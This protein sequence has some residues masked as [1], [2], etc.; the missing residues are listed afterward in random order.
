VDPAVDPQGAFEKAR[1]IRCLSTG[2]RTA[3][4]RKGQA[5]TSRRTGQPHGGGDRRRAVHEEERCQGHL[6]ASRQYVSIESPLGTS[7]RDGKLSDLIE[8]ANGHEPEDDLLTRDLKDTIR[9]TLM[10]LS[11][12]E[13]GDQVPLRAGGVKPMSLK[14]WARCSGDQGA[15]PPDRE[16]GDQGL[17][18]PLRSHKWKISSKADS[19]RFKKQKTRRRAVF[20]FC[21]QRGVSRFFARF[22]RHRR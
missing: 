21:R 19:D 3:A 16:K 15:D 2:Q 4:D 1:L 14:E 8:D 10:T 7:D 9:K 11:E 20:F 18:H 17:K 12:N 5:G 13:R 22:C 6:N